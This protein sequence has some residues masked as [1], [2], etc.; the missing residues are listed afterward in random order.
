MKGRRL[1]LGL[2]PW[3]TLLSFIRRRPRSWVVWGD[4]PRVVARRF[5]SLGVEI[6][7]GMLP[8][9]FHRGEI[10]EWA[11]RSWRG[12]IVPALGKPLPSRL[13]VLRHLAQLSSPLFTASHGKISRAP[14]EIPNADAFSWAFERLERPPE[15]ISAPSVNTFSCVRVDLLGDVL[16]SLPALASLGSEHQL[17]IIVRNDWQEWMNLLL[18]SEI[19]ITGMVLEPWISPTFE[20]ATTAVDLSPPGWGSP[21]TPALARSIPASAHRQIT[22][23]RN[24]DGLAA[25]IGAEFGL[26]VKWPLRSARSS[27]VGLIVPGGSSSERSLPISYWEDGAR[28]SSA[29]MGI[30]K[31]V[32]LDGCDGQAGAI[33]AAIPNAHPLSYPQPPSSILSL[34]RSVCFV[35]GVSTGITHLAALTGTPALVIEHPTTAPWLYRAPVPFVRYL[36]PEHPWWCDDPTEHDLDRALESSNDSYGFLPGEWHRLVEEALSTMASA[37]S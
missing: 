20:S 33:A 4:L 5:A 10:P 2:A 12:I 22:A 15:V 14:R 1:L 6:R 29:A 8:K 25:M 9:P 35:L 13:P 18:P 32:I 16:L 3:P 28:R 36:R 17:R 7:A 19:Q 24:H 31:W 27:D 11:C 34:C 21:L 23:R 37:Q 30:T 26:D